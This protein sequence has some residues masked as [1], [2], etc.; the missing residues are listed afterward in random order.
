MQIFRKLDG[1]GGVASMWLSKAMT[2]LNIER[3][4]NVLATQNDNF[5]KVSAQPC[6]LV[7]AGG[8]RE[9]RSGFCG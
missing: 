8:G 6:V 7:A 9:S 1:V 2:S 3:L 5:R 4:P